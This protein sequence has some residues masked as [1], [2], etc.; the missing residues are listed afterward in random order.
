MHTTKRNKKGP[1]NLAD[2][3]ATGPDSADPGHPRRGG[4]RH[5]RV[6]PEAG[7]WSSRPLAVRPDREDNGSTPRPPLGLARRGRRRRLVRDA[8]RPSQWTTRRAQA[9]GGSWTARG[10]ELEGRRP[11]G[12][13]RGRRW[14]RL[15]S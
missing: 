7:G 4:S 1:K 3:A 12:G 5:R 15:D 13:A 8:G 2:L 11:S 6:E 9:V 14:R 10:V